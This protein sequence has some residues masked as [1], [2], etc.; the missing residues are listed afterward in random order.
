MQAERL[1]VRYVPLET[2]E[3]LDRNPKRHDLEKLAASIRKF[4]FKDPPRFEPRLNGGKGGV[5]EGN[6]RS[7]VLRRMSQ[8]GEEPPRGIGV[9]E[10]GAWHVPVLFGVDAKSQAEAE[11]YGIDHN[12]LTLAGANFDLE[13]LLQIYDEEQLQALLSG[14]PDTATLLVSLDASDLDAL[15]KGPDFDP[16]AAGDQPRLDEK[17]PITCPACGHE[18]TR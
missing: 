13:D 7:I 3:L 6:G 8:A 16:V 2:L 4:G 18:F 17:V 14:A 15:L 11:A 5:V 1:Q 9:D 12:S 10:A